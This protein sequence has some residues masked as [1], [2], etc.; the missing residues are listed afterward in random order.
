MNDLELDDN[1]SDNDIDMNGDSNDANSDSDSDSDSNDYT[2]YVYEP[3]EQS[4]TKFNIVLCERFNESIHGPADECEDLKNHYLTYVRFKELNIDIINEF[5]E[6][7]PSSLN[8]EIV[9]VI[10]LPSNHCVSIIKTFWLKIIQKKWKKI[11][12][13]RKECILRRT[14][15]NAIKHKEIYGKWSK[16]SLNLNYPI[17]R[18]MLATTSF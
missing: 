3:L 6:E 9:Q 16:N 14:N 5:K 11:C 12:K 18:G 8:L 17:L 15:L 4:L 2:N 10:Y 13:E 1:V 7:A